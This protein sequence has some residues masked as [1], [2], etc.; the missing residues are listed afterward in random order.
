MMPRHEFTPEERSRGGKARSQQPSFK[1]ACSKGFEVTMV[2][3]PFFAR[4]HLKAK[5]KQFNESKKNKG[6][7]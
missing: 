2:R 3:H 1:D 6:A 5:I 7:Q 4:K